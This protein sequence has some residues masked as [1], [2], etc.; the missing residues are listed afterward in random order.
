MKRLIVYL[1]LTFLYCQCFPN[2]SSKDNCLSIRVKKIRFYEEKYKDDFSDYFLT[3][4]IVIE[5]KN[6]SDSI[7]SFH[8]YECSWQERFI[9][10]NESFYLQQYDC[11]TNRGFYIDLKPG[12]SKVFDGLL[13][14]RFELNQTINKRFKIGFIFIEP[15][16]NNY[17]C[18]CDKDDWKFQKKKEDWKCIIWSKEYRIKIKRHKIR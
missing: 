1:V 11:P 14:G 6:I 17:C 8:Y 7:V 4:N 5:I 16:Y 9:F 13:V 15:S 3:Y 2:G 12:E 10:D 18:P